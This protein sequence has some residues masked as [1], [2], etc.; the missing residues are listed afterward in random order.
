MYENVLTLRVRTPIVA[1]IAYPRNIITKML[2]HAYVIDIP[3]LDDGVARSA[4]V[5]SIHGQ[6]Q[7]DGDCKIPQT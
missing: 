1:N 3:K 5:G 6:A 7:C 4:A 2:T